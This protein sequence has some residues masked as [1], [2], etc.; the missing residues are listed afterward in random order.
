MKNQHY[1]IVLGVMILTCFGCSK[2][3]GKGYYRNMN[4]CYSNLKAVHSELAL[5]V[6]NTGSESNVCKIAE[7]NLKHKSFKCPVTNMRYAINPDQL[8]WKELQSTNAAI[9]CPV[10]HPD[11]TSNERNYLII[12]FEGK[13]GKVSTLPNWAQ[14]N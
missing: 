3:L 2:R 14:D 1:F 8:K 7:A 4:L 11:P 12:S 6:I 9:A 13:L 10:I 5:S